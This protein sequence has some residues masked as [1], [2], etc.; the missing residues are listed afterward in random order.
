MSE[1]IGWE[2]KLRMELWSLG[3]ESKRLFE[4]LPQADPQ[5]LSD[6]LD[7]LQIIQARIADKL[8]ALR[9]ILPYQK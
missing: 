6:L 7:E 2:R 9:A 8:M 5:R 3:E 4:E 1:P